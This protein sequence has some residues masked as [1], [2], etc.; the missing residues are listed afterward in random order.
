[1]HSANGK[2]KRKTK[3]GIL[4]AGNVVKELHLPGLCNMPDVDVSWLCDKVESQASNLCE[5]K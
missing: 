5:H 3:V 1:M 4:G 2:A